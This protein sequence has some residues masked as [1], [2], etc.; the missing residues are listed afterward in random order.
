MSIPYSS[1]F[2]LRSAWRYRL[3]VAVRPHRKFAQLGD[4][5]SR[6]F[7]LRF[8]RML[9]ADGTTGYFWGPWWMTFMTFLPNLGW[10]YMD[11]TE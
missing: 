1:H 10:V 7:L 2:F 6:D 8:W 11:L 5:V 4:L 3:G 9:G